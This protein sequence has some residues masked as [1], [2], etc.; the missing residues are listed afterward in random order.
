MAS[1][2]SSPKLA[3]AV[4]VASVA[5]DPTKV[6]VGWDVYPCPAIFIVMLITLP[7]FI[8]VTAL[9]PVPPPPVIDT[10]GAVIYPLPGFVR[11]IP[12]SCPDVYTPRLYNGD[13]LYSHS[14]PVAPPLSY[15]EPVR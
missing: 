5:F 10:V 4:A 11:V 6:T 9:A 12:V 3:N 7:S 2:D 15:S 13:S 8:S 14:T 1:L